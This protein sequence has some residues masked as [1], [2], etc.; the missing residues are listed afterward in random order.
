MICT[1]LQIHF[2]IIKLIF[3]WKVSHK[4]SFWN[5]GTRIH[6]SMS[7]S[8]E[9]LIIVMFLLCC[10][11]VQ[12]VHTSLTTETKYQHEPFQFYFVVM[13]LEFLRFIVNTLPALWHAT[14]LCKSTGKLCACF[15][16]FRNNYFL[17]LRWPLWLSFLFTN[18]P[19]NTSWPHHSRIQSSSSAVL[20]F[21]DVACDQF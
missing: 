11:V 5:R 10:Y 13:L 4:D 12:H 14:F 9:P 1:S 3:I 7:C 21:V 8:Q 17:V 20:L 16:S 19:T 15:I 18:P 2:M 6:S